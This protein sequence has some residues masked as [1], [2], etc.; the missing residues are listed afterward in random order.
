MVERVEWV[1]ITDPQTAVN[2]LVRGEVDAVESVPPDL[3]PLLEK[4]KGLFLKP[5]TSGQYFA[6][7][8]HAH[9]PFDNPKIRQ[10]AMIALSQ[11][12]ILKG[13]VGDPKYYKV[14]RSMYACGSPLATDAGMKELVKGDAKRAAASGGR[15]PVSSTS[16]SPRG[17]SDRYVTAQKP[18]N[19]WPSTDQRPRE[20]PSRGT[21]ARRTHSASRTMESARK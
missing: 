2:A 19:D 15:P 13:A 7:M 8:N 9:P 6:R 4:E 17:A 5:F 10:A 11:E 3:L 16:V 1:N 12:Q 14:C 18:P 20:G 21:R